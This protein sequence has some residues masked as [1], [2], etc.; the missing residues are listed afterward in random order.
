MCLFD[1]LTPLDALP[2]RYA[3]HGGGYI[4]MLCKKTTF[5]QC[6]TDHLSEPIRESSRTQVESWFMSLVYLCE[7][8][9]WLLERKADRFCHS[10][11]SYL[12]CIWDC[13]EANVLQFADSQ[14]L[15]YQGQQDLN[16]PLAGCK[17][18]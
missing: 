16:V 11:D 13:F 18:W 4:Y 9:H 15:E 5:E 12:K 2:L 17:T 8:F 14:W 10:E 6:R 3:N 1:H 7:G